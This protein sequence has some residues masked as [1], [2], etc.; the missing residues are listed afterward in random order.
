MSF[1]SAP[2]VRTR[3]RL[4]VFESEPVHFT[5]FT[6]KVLNTS[7]PALSRTVYH[8]E[9]MR[10]MDSSRHFLDALGSIL[11][12]LRCLCPLHQAA[13]IDKLK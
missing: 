4:M 6:T 8:T 2:M 1:L 13:A 7:C 9:L 5:T 3:S 12:W 11:R 10:R